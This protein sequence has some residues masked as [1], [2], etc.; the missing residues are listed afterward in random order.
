M[1]PTIADH[2]WSE[3]APPGIVFQPFSVGSIILLPV[4]LNVTGLNGSNPAQN[5]LE[6]FC[7]AKRVFQE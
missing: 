7:G 2:Q 5:G 6:C 1:R 3:L 4:Q